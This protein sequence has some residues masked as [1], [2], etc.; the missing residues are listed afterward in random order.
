M[1][2]ILHLTEIYTSSTQERNKH[3]VILYIP[4][5]KDHP[6]EK[7]RQEH[8][9]SSGCLLWQQPPT[10]KQ[11]GQIKCWSEHWK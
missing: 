4:A 11:Q 2:V 9:S 10:A 7:Y 6:A 5:Q 3:K 8:Q 1:P